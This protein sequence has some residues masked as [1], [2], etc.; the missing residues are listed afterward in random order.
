MRVWLATAAAPCGSLKSRLLLVVLDSACG[1][2]SC[3]GGIL[4]GVST[5]LPLVEEVVAAVQL[6]VD[7]LQPVALGVRQAAP[8]T[9]FLVQAFLFAR[10]RVDVLEDVRVCH[11]TTPHHSWTGDCWP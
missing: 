8:V 6:D 10:K 9:G 5:T 7:G 2:E 3:F 1:P 4:T 11:V